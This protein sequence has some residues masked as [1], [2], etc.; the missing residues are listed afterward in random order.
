M[1]PRKS[2]KANVQMKWRQS[3]SLFNFTTFV[4][5]LL[6]RNL[7]FV[8]VGLSDLTMYVQTTLSSWHLVRHGS[9]SQQ[10]ACEGFVHGR[11]SLSENSS[12]TPA[13]ETVAA[14]TKAIT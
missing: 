3:L 8:E 11:I 1:F 4:F 10:G 14:P 12:A 2:Q 13:D 9:P 7:M 5:V 6:S